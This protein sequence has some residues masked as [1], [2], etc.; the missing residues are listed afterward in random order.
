MWRFSRLR[1]G[2]GMHRLKTRGRRARLE[3][4]VDVLRA[5]GSGRC[6]PTEIMYATN[7]SW[8]PVCFF[9]ALMIEHDLISKVA[10]G[11]NMDRKRKWVYQLTGKGEAV[12]MTYEKLNSLIFDFHPKTT[13]RERHKYE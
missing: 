4:I 10:T 13:L 5:V 11:E 1:L 7:T 2:W 6:G 8:G 12:L 9:L 3:L